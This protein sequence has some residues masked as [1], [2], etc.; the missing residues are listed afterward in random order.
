MKDSFW[1]WGLEEEKGEKKRHN[2][3]IKKKLKAKA[4]P[5]KKKDTRPKAGTR[6]ACLFQ[7]K[8]G[9]G[10]WFNGTVQQVHKKTMIVAFDDGDVRRVTHEKGTWQYEDSPN[11]RRHQN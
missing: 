11:Q 4:P 1:H 10:R 5:V 7:M 2:E 6:V 9:R 3:F 8:Q